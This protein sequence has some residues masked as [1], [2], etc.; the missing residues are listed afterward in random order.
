MGRF[1]IARHSSSAI[2]SSS[3]PA[4]GSQQSVMNYA[5]LIIGI[6]FDDIES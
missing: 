5:K 4:L 3:C 6:S 2:H 1:P